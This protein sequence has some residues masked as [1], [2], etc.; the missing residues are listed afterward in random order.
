[1]GV[2]KKS[3]RYEMYLRH[4]KA[5]IDYARPL[6]GSRQDAEDIV[7]EAYLHFVPEQ[8]SKPL[9][10]K[11]YLFRIVRN[12]SFNMRSKRKRHDAIHPGDIPWWALSQPSETPEEELLVHE[13]IKRAADAMVGLPERTR[14]ALQM[15]RFDGLTLTEISVELGVSVATA[16]RLVRDAI[17]EIKAKMDPRA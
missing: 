4:R 5:L 11:A 8:E 2:G 6:V 17:A 13:Q 12:L 15:Y 16:H 7:Q 10:A 14:K 3:E 1:M 9:P